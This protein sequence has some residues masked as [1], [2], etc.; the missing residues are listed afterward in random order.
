[1]GDQ[2][3]T[4]A[5]GPCVTGDPLL[6]AEFLH[7]I[8]TAADSQYTGKVTVPWD[9]ARA[10]IVSNETAEIIRMFNLAFDDLGASE[11]DYY[12]PNCGPS[13]R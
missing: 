9:K 3:W 1:M 2:G 8:Y 5:L 13:T 4:F 10:T 12:P 11:G 7:Q 6:G